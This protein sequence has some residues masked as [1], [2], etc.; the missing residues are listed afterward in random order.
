MKTFNLT[1]QLSKRREQVIAKYNELTNEQFFD[2]CT[3]RT[4]MVEIM[5][6]CQINH[7][8]SEKTLDAKLAFFIGNIYC[9]HKKIQGT[10]KVTNALR[11]KYQC[12]AFMALV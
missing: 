3:L 4:F 6:M 11:N 8:A 9:S 1:E 5:Q 7:I 12:T 2:G 10:D